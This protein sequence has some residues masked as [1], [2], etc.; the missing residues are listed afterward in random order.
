MKKSLVVITSLLAL[1]VA[2]AAAAETTELAR[3]EVPSQEVKTE[4]DF[5]ALIKRV[6]EEAGKHEC[7]TRARAEGRAIPGKI[8]IERQGEKIVLKSI[9]ESCGE[10]KL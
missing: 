9:G 10:R 4:E 3:I 7:I 1:G 8:I 6:Y 5:N 2:F